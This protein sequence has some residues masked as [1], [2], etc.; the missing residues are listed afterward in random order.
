M[1]TLEQ[2]KRRFAFEWQYRH[3][4]KQN[5]SNLILLLRHIRFMKMYRDILTELN[6]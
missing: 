2:S 6:N 3:N 1:G 5:Y 4:S